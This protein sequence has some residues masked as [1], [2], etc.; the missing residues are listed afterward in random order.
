MHQVYYLFE[1]PLSLIDFDLR[2]GHPQ[3][4]RLEQVLSELTHSRGSI[5]SAHA[6]TDLEGQPTRRERL[7]PISGDRVVLSGKDI[8]VL[9]DLHC[10][11][12]FLAIYSAWELPMKDKLDKLPRKPLTAYVLSFSR[13]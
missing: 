6:Y 11:S 13:F 1:Y 2:T 4:V 3:T 5:H 8:L 12:W 9:S 10:Q 7:D